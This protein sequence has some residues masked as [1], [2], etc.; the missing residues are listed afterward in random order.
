MPSRPSALS[1]D[2]HA[3][4]YNRRWLLATVLS[5]V[6]IALWDAWGQDLAMAHLWG[7]AQGFALRDDHFLVTYMHQ[8]MRNLGWVV[9]LA[10]S[11]G[12]W[13]PF[14]LLRQLPTARR[15]QLL[16]SILASLAVV[17]ILKRSSA[18]SCPWD[19]S[20]FGGVADYVSHW[21]WGL[22]DGGAGHC[23]PAGHAAAGFSFVGG[24]FALARNAPRAARW[25]LAV[26]LAVGLLLGVGQQMRGAH[27]MSHTL[28]TAWLCWTAGLAID[29]AMARRHRQAAV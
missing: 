8:G 4:L 1:V 22:H 27:Y 14:G 9:V 13:L 25:W 19:L 29:M 10:L 2:T 17:A 5:F 6:L 21:R 3:P 16:V 11:L 18:T 28:W 20:M 7:T 15:V 24:Y 26:S 23:F 12:V